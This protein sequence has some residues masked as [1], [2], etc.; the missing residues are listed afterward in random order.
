MN[1]LN[2][3]SNLAQLSRFAQ[4]AASVDSESKKK[5]ATDVTGR[6]KGYAKDGRGKVEYDGKIYY[7]HVMSSSCKQLDQPVNLR[8]T[9]SGVFVDWQ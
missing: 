6:W 9:K 3:V 5:N 1:I 7:A 8:R 4:V 2:E